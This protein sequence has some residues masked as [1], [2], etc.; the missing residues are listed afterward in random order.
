MRGQED[1]CISPEELSKAIEDGSF[2]STFDHNIR[3]ERRPF[4][5]VGAA[6]RALRDDV[7]GNCLEDDCILIAA[8]VIITIGVS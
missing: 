3:L 1:D 8:L 7:A 4:E 5:R 6:L 2:E